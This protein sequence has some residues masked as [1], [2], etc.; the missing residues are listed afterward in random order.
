MD[1]INSQNHSKSNNSFG[2]IDENLMNNISLGAG[3]GVS[4]NSGTADESGSS[5]TYRIKD[6]PPIPTKKTPTSKQ[7][8][9]NISNSHIPTYPTQFQQPKFSQQYSENDNYNTYDEQ[10][11]DATVE[12]VKFNDD[13]LAEL[14]FSNSETEDD[15]DEEEEN[16]ENK[17]NNFNTTNNNNDLFEPKKIEIENSLFENIPKFLKRNFDYN[18][19]EIVNDTNKEQVDLFNES[20]D[21]LMNSHRVTAEKLE[22]QQIKSDENRLVNVE[23]A[24]ESISKQN[25][26]TDLSFYNTSQNITQNERINQLVMQSVERLKRFGR[27]AEADLY[28]TSLSNHLNQNLVKPRFSSSSIH[29]VKSNLNNNIK[30]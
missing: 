5:Q 26:E 19:K 16:D 12:S 3:F 14:E 30:S 8:F 7:P 9:G 21:I 15:D 4:N 11:G 18:K 24:N 23:N 2:L 27:N 6:K 25:N 28:N 13:D 10:M 20:A 17:E 22:D 29:T 1:L